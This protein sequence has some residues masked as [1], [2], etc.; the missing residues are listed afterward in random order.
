MLTEFV[1]DLY[2]DYPYRAISLPDLL[3]PEEA[4]HNRPSSLFR[5]DTATAAIAD[6]YDAPAGF[7]MSSPQFVPRQ[8]GSSS[9]T[10]GYIVC[11]A[12]G[13]TTKEVWVFRADHLQDGPICKL[14][15]PD[16]QFGFTMHTAWLAAIA[17]RT[18]H[19]QVPIRPDYEPRL[20]QPAVQQI[21][22]ESVFPHFE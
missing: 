16:L 6:A 10:D 22:N 20:N 5:I 9:A 11:T 21:F 12:F 13:E 18:S 1:Y 7:F 8:N 2:T 14:S 15:H 19:Y 3:N 4:F 17:P